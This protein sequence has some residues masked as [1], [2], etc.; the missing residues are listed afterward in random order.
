MN[1]PAGRIFPFSAAFAR[2]YFC[3]IYAS[4]AAYYQGQ[5]SPA[6]DSVKGAE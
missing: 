5:S 3:M 4:R 1:N 6:G 2:R